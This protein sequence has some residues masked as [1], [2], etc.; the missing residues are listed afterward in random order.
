[1]PNIAPIKEWLDGTDIMN[2]LRPQGCS[3][4]E[5]NE[6]R[7]SL[8]QAAAVT[9]LRNWMEVSIL[10]MN[11]ITHSHEQPL[12]DIE[13]IRWR[14]EF[15]DAVGN[16][17]HIHALMWLKEGSEVKDTTLDRIRGSIMDMIRSEEIDLLVAGG[18]LANVND[19]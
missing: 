17:P 9:L 4:A 13:L 3:S 19:I 5:E 10:Y 12:G 14:C 6:L 7:T 1:M 18:L 11:Y 2:I 16:L 8:K 15:Q